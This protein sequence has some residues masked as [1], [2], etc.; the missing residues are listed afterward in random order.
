MLFV[1]LLAAALLAAQSQSKSAAPDPPKTVEVDP[2]ALT[3]DEIKDLRIADLELKQAQMEQALLQAR[4]RELG[5]QIEQM[6]AS[7][8][9]LKAGIIAARKLP[10]GSR[11]DTEA[12][13]IIAPRAAP[14]APKQGGPY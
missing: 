1:F 5:Q 9:S 7:A 2:L 12:M 13:R 14:T 4:F 8:A 11:I 3:R 10:A 6:K